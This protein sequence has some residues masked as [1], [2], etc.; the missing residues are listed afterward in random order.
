MR[1]FFFTSTIFLLIIGFSSTV[2]AYSYKIDILQGKVNVEIG[3]NY[4]F[5][6]IVTI[7]NIVANLDF[8]AAPAGTLMNYTVSVAI[9]LRPFGM[10]DYSFDVTDMDIGIFQSLDFSGL[11]PAGSAPSE[12][13]AGQ[14]TGIDADFMGYSLT[15]ATLDYDF[16]FTKDDSISNRYFINIAE[17][18]LSNGNTGDILSAII[19]DFADEILPGMILTPPFTI[20]TSLA[21]SMDIQ[22]D[23]VPVPAAIWLLGSGIV[24]LIGFRSRRKA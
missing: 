7:E 6:N 5:I 18:R 11:L 19:T 12:Q 17:F 16:T 8:D 20:P 22:A 2:L 24:G 4:S 23:P 21:G 9:D 14:K 13:T 10:I 1:K 15:G 3:E